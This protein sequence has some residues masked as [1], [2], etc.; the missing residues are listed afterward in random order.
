MTRSRKKTDKLDVVYTVGNFSFQRDDFELRMSLRSLE[1]QDWVGQVYL[2][3]HCPAWARNVIHLP[4]GDP[5]KIKDANMINKVR[6]AVDTFDLTEKFVVNSDDHYI[7]RPITPDELGPWR[8]Q[9]N[10]ALIMKE[11]N[12]RKNSSEWC[13]RLLRTLQWC[14][15]NGYP[16]WVFQCHTPYPMETAKVHE[17]Y[18]KLPYDKDLGIVIHGYYNVALEEEPPVEP[19]GSTFRLTVAMFEQQLEKALRNAT[20][21][22]HSD[23]GYNAAARSWM[24]K[25]WPKP[26]RWEATEGPSP[27]AKKQAVGNRIRVM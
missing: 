26:S 18:S 5:S 1:Y 6:A 25:K 7:L 17:A 9:R 20:F 13:A 19:E 15:K 23:I 16:E 8:E 27:F 4:M 3:G 2:I 22:N 21:F 11:L 12:M 24:L 10:M 14:K